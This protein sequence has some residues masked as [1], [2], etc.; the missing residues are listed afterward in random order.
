MGTVFFRNGAEKN[1]Y[2]LGGTIHYRGAVNS[3]AK[4]F[5]R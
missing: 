2:T 5:R 4:N 1:G 3:G